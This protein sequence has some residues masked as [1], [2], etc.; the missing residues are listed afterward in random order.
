MIHFFCLIQHDRLWR[1]VCRCLFDYSRRTR[2]RPFRLVFVVQKRN[3][4][5][6]CIGTSSST[7]TSLQRREARKSRMHLG[8]QRS[9]GLR[10]FCLPFLH[11]LEHEVF[12]IG[13]MPF[14]NGIKLWV[15]CLP[16]FNHFQNGVA[17][18]V[19]VEMAIVLLGLWFSAWRPTFF[20]VSGFIKIWIFQNVR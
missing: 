9:N 7:L 1:L 10:R 6:G 20:C 11:F 2:G 18:G 19:R 17:Q 15:V 4:F 5:G 3:S 8:N 16:V 12:V 14:N 13:K